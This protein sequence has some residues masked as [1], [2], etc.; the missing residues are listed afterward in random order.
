MNAKIYRNG[1]FDRDK[2]SAI[3]L[4][5]SG[6]FLIPFVMAVGLVKWLHLKVGYDNQI[7]NVLIFAVLLTFGALGYI[8]RTLTRIRPLAYKQGDL[9][10][11]NTGLLMK[12]TVDLS[13][14]QKITCLYVTEHNQLMKIRTP[15][16]LPVE[17]EIK[18]TDC[19]TEDLGS[20][21]TENH[22]IEVRYS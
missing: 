5:N 9:L 18:Q 12:K 19:S 3:L 16:E 21:I 20:F 22:D 1:K 2:I 11:I 4:K 13:K 8:Y 17:F 15:G 10:I 6:I 7:V 14:A